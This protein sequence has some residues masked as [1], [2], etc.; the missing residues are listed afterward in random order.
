MFLFVFRLFGIEMDT[1]AD[2]LNFS[3]ESWELSMACFTGEI[4]EVR[5]ICC[6]YKVNDWNRGLYW[7]VFGLSHEEYTDFDV[8]NKYIQ[9]VLLMLHQGADIGKCRIWLTNDNVYQLIQGGTRNF[10]IYV[11]MA[12]DILEWKEK[13][14]YFLSSYLYDDIHALVLSY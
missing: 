7:A 13:I 1:S 8:V 2:R 4:E 12:R 14:G 3:A 11:D 6:K 10:G 5:D 9:I